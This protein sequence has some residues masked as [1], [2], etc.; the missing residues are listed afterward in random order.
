M[1]KTLTK[2]LLGLGFAGFLGGCAGINSSY[3][4]YIDSNKD[5]KK[6][7]RCVTALNSKEKSIL[8]RCEVDQDR[9]GIT[10]YMVEL[11][12]TPDL[13]KIKRDCNA[14]SKPEKEMTYSIKDGTAY[15]LEEIY[16]THTNPN[17][18]KNCCRTVKTYERDS[19]KLITKITSKVHD[20]KDNIPN[21]NRIISTEIER[22]SGKSIKAIKI[23]MDIR[24]DGKIEAAVRTY[25]SKRD[26]KNNILEEI[27]EIDYGVRDRIDGKNDYRMILGY[28]DDD[29]ILVKKLFDNEGKEITVIPY[30]VTFVMEFLDWPLVYN[31]EKLLNENV[32]KDID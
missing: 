6:D 8:M 32:K 24:G 26:D 15:L 12:Q 31:L 5:G 22:E 9:D 2:L 21:L 14:D 16:E 4:D 20:Y 10:D 25:V 7:T 30:D 13:L 19:N 23:K 11:N 3:I 29:S 18:K 17:S 1:K 27:V 28:N